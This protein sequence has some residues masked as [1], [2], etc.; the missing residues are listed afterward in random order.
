VWGFWWALATFTHYVQCLAA[1]KRFRT[2]GWRMLPFGPRR[3]RRLPLEPLVKLAL[4]LVG[5]LGELWLGHE[6]YR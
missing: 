1:K 5:I 4:P 3:L 6:S 2:R